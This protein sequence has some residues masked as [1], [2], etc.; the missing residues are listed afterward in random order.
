[1]VPPYSSAVAELSHRVLPVTVAVPP[2]LKMAPP[3]RAELPV[4]ALALTVSVPKFSMPPPSPWE[5]LLVKVLA[6]TVSE[7]SEK[8]VSVHFSTAPCCGRYLGGPPP[9]IRRQR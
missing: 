9:P 8:S 1:M 3:A 7:K 2:Y 5:E 4:K 6:L